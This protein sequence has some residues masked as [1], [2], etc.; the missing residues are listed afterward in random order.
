MSYMSTTFGEIVALAKD[1]TPASR[2]R[3]ASCFGDAFF[4]HA[5]GFSPSEKAIALE[6]M[7]ALLRSA[8]LD[9]RRELSQRFAA[10]SA[11]PRALAVG[12]ANDVIE[13][14]RPILLHSPVL[15][16]SDLVG[17]IE[18]KGTA[19][20]MAVANRAHISPRVTEA[21]VQS[22]EPMVAMT[23]LNNIA[24]HLSAS[25]ISALANQA[26]DHMEIS[27]ALM[28]RPEL[29]ADIAEHLY[30]L[31]S[32][33]LRH[34]I[35]GRFDINPAVL[36]RALQ[37]TVTHLISRDN[38]PALR[39]TMAERLIVSGAVSPNFLIELLKARGVSLFRQLMQTVTGFN[40]E[41]LEVLF[42]PRGT[43]PLALVCRA[44][45]FNKVE[46][47]SFIML[48]RD[49]VAGQNQFDP[50]GLS[51]ALATF[52]RLT[53]GDANTVLWQWQNDPSYLLSLTERLS[54]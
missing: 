29:T 19:H 20:R 8:E 48:V 41:A 49:R 14:A 38:D 9:I 16:E 43:E 3:L 30:W 12:L 52:G 37:S 35:K 25:T 46:A 1:P 51:G 31:V 11:I 34:E 26:F 5:A 10:E 53:V 6:I 42:Q 13:V 22:R 18:H 45:G 4:I 27:H 15:Q 50:A 21:L 17:V 47:A 2:R 32:E 44:L 40:E 36:D 28:L 54:H 23:L 33:E 39:Q 24:V 7:A